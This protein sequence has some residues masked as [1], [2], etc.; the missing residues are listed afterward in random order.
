M[1]FNSNMHVSFISFV[2][3][4]ALLCATGAHAVMDPRFE[5][6]P[7]ALAHMKSAGKPQRTAGKRFPRIHGKRSASTFATGRVYTIK[8]GDHLFKILMRDYGLSNGEAELLVEEI[9]RENNIY[10]IKRLKIG[11]KIS[12]P[13]VR[14]HADGSLAPAQTV[15]PDTT[16]HFGSDIVPG[17]SFKLESP[18]VAL[19]EQ[20]AVARA[21]DMWNRIVPP[22]AEQQKPLSIQTAAFSLTLDPNRYPMFARVDGGF[23]VVD[24][25]GT[26]PPLVK[27]LIEDKYASVRI[28]AEAP[29]ETKRFMLSLLE[30]AGF[31]SVEKNFTMEFGADP[32]LTIQTDFKVEKTVESIIKQDVVLVNSRR[33]S[34]PPVLGEFLKTEGFLL[35]EPFVTLKSFARYDTRA[36]N[37]I[38]AKKQPEMIDS[39]LSALSVTPE[40]DRSVDI[41]AADH[42]GISL[43]VKA[44]RYFERGG[45]RY[46]VTRF[47]GD[48]INYTLFRILE[49]T[50]CSV[51]IIEAQDD[52]RKIAEKMISRMKMKGVYTQHR[53]LQDETAGYSLQMSGFKIDDAMLPGGGVFLTDRAMD[54]VIRD[55]FTQNGFSITNR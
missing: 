33:A 24:Q 17:Q 40:R 4:I 36:I 5:L 50:G 3:S 52:F 34:L 6:D 21:H 47:D 28:V 25:N 18:V 35:Y 39:I 1:P 15:L 37:H 55:L 22:K 44:E 45:Q 26:I 48:P 27:S 8:P 46:I 49:T 13:P 41:F 51:I 10:D 2:C 29:S 7:E 30:A 31:Y 38:S 19:S 54:R 32:K 12:I 11:Q 16:R 14:R 23:I 53:M 20:D 43:S 42:N 9:K